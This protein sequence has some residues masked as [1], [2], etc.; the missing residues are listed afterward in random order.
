MRG[1]EIREEGEGYSI[2]VRG[3]WVGQ[4]WHDTRPDDC[5]EILERIGKVLGIEVEYIEGL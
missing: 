1:I 5:L 3:V 2:W 4:V